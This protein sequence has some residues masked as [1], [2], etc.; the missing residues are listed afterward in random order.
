M[1]FFTP[2]P[3]VSH[4]TDTPIYGFPLPLDLQIILQVEKNVEE[5]CP[6][7][8]FYQEQQTYKANQKVCESHR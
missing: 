5:M 7:T 2:T 8:I 1:M 3:L 4:Y 6:K